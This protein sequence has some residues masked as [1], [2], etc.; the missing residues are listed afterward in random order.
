M[1]WMR[2]L[3]APSDGEVACTRMPPIS[4]SSMT[5]SP[6]VMSIFSLD[7]F[8]IE[9]FH[10]DRLVLDAA[11]RAGAGDH[12]D[13]FFDRQGRLELDPD[14]MLGARANGDG[15]GDRQESLVHRRDLHHPRRRLHARDPGGI[16][17]VRGSRH[18]HGNPRDR[19][20]ARA[21]LDADASRFLCGYT[22]RHRG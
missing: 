9:G 5:T 17:L 6:G 11:A 4:L 18:D 12:R 21:H 8:P 1:P 22:G 13:L 20:P 10:A 19:A 2:R 15:H 14:D 16:G 7:L 3:A